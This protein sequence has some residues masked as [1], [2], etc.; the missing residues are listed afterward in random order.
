MPQ[1]LK[2]KTWSSQKHLPLLISIWYLKQQCHPS[3]PS[4]GSPGRLWLFLFLTFA[5]PAYPATNSPRPVSSLFTVPLPSTHL[6]SSANILV[7]VL[8][9]QTPKHQSLKQPPHPWVHSI[10]DHLFWSNLSAGQKLRWLQVKT[11]MSLPST[12]GTPRLQPYLWP[13]KTGRL[14]PWAHL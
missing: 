7:Q 9:I 13:S 5:R 1:Y 3:L 4:S 6:A 12:H 8:I 2:C 10:P 11:W 14:Y